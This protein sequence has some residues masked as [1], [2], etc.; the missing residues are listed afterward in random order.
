ML[1]LH[2]CVCL[3][4]EQT[5]CDCCLFSTHSL[6]DFPALLTPCP[7]LRSA[8]TNLQCEIDAAL[9]HVLHCMAEAQAAAGSGAPGIVSFGPGPSGSASSGGSNTRLN[10]S[11][12][13]NDGGSSLPPLDM[14]RPVSVCT[15]PQPERCSRGRAL[16]QLARRHPASPTTAPAP[17]AHHHHRLYRLLP[18]CLCRPYR[19]DVPSGAAAPQACLHEAGHQPD[20][21]A[22]AGRGRGAA[23][24]PR[25]PAGPAG[26]GGLTGGQ[27]F[28]ERPAGGQGELLSSRR[29]SYMYIL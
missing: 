18:Y 4:G 6:A 12:S 13:S 5:L 21:H 11:S 14:Y 29:T 9:Q 19:A 7:A 23:H 22:G 15:A 28:T 8:A 2:A 16:L 3:V 20:L 26:G 27:P 10:G 24:V 1:Q 25:L 17:T